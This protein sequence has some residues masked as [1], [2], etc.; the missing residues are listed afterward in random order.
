[1]LEIFW[2]R[3]LVRGA[4]QLSIDKTG[5]KVPVTASRERS[6]MVPEPFGLGVADAPDPDPDGVAVE[7]G[8]VKKKVPANG[9]PRPIASLN[10]VML[11]FVR[12][13]DALSID[14]AFEANPSD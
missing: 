4:D 3:Y 1:V 6:K 13:V 2:A 12:G 8:P 14:G 7:S 11:K 9:A 10:A 5:A